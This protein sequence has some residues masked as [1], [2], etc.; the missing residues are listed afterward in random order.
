MINLVLCV[1][2]DSSLPRMMLVSTASAGLECIVLGC[3]AVKCDNAALNDRF[4][5]LGGEQVESNRE[6]Q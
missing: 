6:A 2:T 4:E 1:A 3:I 5:H